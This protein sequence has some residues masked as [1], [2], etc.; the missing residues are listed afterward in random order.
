MVL[1]QEV[2]LAK[3]NLLLVRAISSV[4]GFNLEKVPISL[5]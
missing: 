3:R 4:S 2:A 1:V 5:E